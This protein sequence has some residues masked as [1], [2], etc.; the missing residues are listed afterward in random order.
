MHMHIGEKIYKLRRLNNETMND[1]VK[2]TGVSKSWLSDIESG[3]KQRVDFTDK[4]PDKKTIG[5]KRDM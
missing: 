5:H 4:Y 1:L 3:K 2:Q